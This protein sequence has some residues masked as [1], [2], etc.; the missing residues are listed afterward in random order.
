MVDPSTHTYPRTTD[1]YTVELKLRVNSSEFVTN[2]GV[3]TVPTFYQSGGHH[4][5]LLLQEVITTGGQDPHG[6]N[7]I[8]VIDS[9]SFVVNTGISTMW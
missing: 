5:F 1:P 6:T 2:V 9:T 7:V 3:S 8:Q 4:L